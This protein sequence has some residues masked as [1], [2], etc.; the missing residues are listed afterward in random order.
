EDR[1]GRR[2]SLVQGGNRERTPG[3]P[4]APRSEDRRAGR[5]GLR[6]GAPR[7]RSRGLRRTGHGSPER[8]VRLGR[9]SSLRRL[10]GGVSERQA[11]EACRGPTRRPAFDRRRDGGTGSDEGLRQR[12][13]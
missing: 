7:P 9:L 10:G 5:A 8:Q 4:P 2:A 1:T 6:G 12:V 3:P 13:L 11:V